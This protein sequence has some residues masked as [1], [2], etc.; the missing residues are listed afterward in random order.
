[1]PV[2]SNPPPKRHKFPQQSDGADDKNSLIP[3][4]SP[5]CVSAN[6]SGVGCTRG[7][8][9]HTQSPPKYHGFLTCHVGEFQWVAMF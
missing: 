3:L 5:Y 8:R 9:Q 7:P 2:E 1:M 6:D 4:N